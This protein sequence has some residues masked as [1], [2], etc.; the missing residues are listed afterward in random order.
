MGIVFDDFSGVDWRRVGVFRAR[1]ELAM[2][3]LMM[4]MQGPNNQG[5]F[6]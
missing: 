5:M 2:I 1:S 3:P 6:D 4:Y